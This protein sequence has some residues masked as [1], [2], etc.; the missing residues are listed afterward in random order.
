MA[1]KV[2]LEIMQQ[3]AAGSGALLLAALKQAQVTIVRRAGGESVQHGI[4]LFSQADAALLRVLP[5]LCQ[6]ARVLAIAA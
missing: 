4:V 2:W 5:T 6:Q 3:A 1:L